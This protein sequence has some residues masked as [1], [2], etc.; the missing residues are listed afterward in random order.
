METLRMTSIKQLNNL[1]KYH[2]EMGNMDRVYEIRAKLRNL[3]LC[4]KY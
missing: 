2:Y 3:L 1:A 4:S